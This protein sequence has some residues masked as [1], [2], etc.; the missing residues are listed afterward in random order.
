MHVYMKKFFITCI[1][2]HFLRTWAEATT[3]R[4][5]AAMASMASH[6][7]CTPVPPNGRLRRIR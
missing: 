4:R 2:P 7:F 3:A 5:A 1:Y 6:C